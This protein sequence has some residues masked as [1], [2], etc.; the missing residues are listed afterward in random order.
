MV[1]GVV[2]MSAN[3]KNK[4]FVTGGTGLVG[5]HLLFKLVDQGH[6]PIA[7]KRSTSD[8]KKTLRT[9]NYYSQ[10]ASEL[11]DKIRWV[12]GNLLDY[13]SLLEQLDGVSYVYHC[14][15]SVS[16]QAADKS[17][18]NETNVLGTT[19]VVNACLEK[20]IFKLLHVS[21]IGTLGRADASGIV[22][23]NTHWNNKKT[24]A[25]STSKYNAELEVWRGMAEGL[26][27]VIINPSIILGPS[28]WDEGSSKLFSTVYNGLKFYTQGTN[29]FVDVNDVCNIMIQL[30]KSEIKGERFILNSENVAY[31]DIF[32]WMA[33]ELGVSTP[34]YE[35][36]RFISELA[37]RAL[38]I[39]GLITG[40][41]S[42]ITRET[43]ETANQKYN[44][45]NKKIRD[46]TGYDFIPVRESITS[47][48]RLFLLDKSQ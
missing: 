28:N 25:Y 9:F 21:S 8:L 24:S 2:G 43:A 12:D 23:E 47:T 40:V 35:A 32:G 20:G 22:T 14:G 1:K 46:A 44:Y 15:A 38:Y 19:N 45:S 18:L 6:A 48:A 7:L 31:K 42:S 4:I 26:N 33:H 27:A 30:M 5:S 41:R 10:N 29:G 34:K 36:T 17:I 13:Q 3:K 11:F 16:F 37:W 39:K